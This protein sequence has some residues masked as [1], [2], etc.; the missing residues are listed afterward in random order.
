MA[1]FLKILLRHLKEYCEAAA[2]HGPQH[3]VSPRLAVIERLVL[4]Y[5]LEIYRPIRRYHQKMRF[6]DDNIRISHRSHLKNLIK[7]V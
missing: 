3:I 6:S 1:N 2:I 5:F 4:T 7:S